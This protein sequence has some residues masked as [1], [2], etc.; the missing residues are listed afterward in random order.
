MAEV[1]KKKTEDKYNTE[2]IK[3]SLEKKENKNNKKKT[4]KT[5]KKNA[6]RKGNGI[7]NFFK[8]VGAEFKRVHWPNKKNMIKYSIAT[9]VFIIF[10]GLFFYGINVIF[11]GIMELFK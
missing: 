10:F 9:I 3:K 7:K 11:A 1:L 5:V 2:S 4:Q 8:G 6:D